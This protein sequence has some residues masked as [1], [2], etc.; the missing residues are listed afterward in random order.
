MPHAS[1]R[2]KEPFKLILGV[3]EMFYLILPFLAFVIVLFFVCL[4]M[5]GQT[6]TVVSGLPP[7]PTVVDKVTDGISVYV[8]VVQDELHTHTYILSESEYHSVN[9]GDTVDIH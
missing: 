9:I 5:F 3:K 4:S 6:Q 2:K 7:V 8:V 1:N